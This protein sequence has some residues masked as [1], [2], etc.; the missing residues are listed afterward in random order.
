MA[1][2]SLDGRPVPPELP[3]AQLTA[4][5]HRGEWE[6]RLW[7]AP[8]VALGHV[9]LPRT[10]EAEREFL[11]MSDGTGRYWLTWDGRLDN[12][13]EL[14]PKLGYDV[15]ER[16]EK[17]DA[18]YVLDSF[19]K[20]GDDCVHHL[21]GDWAVV[22]WDNEARRLFCAKDPLGWRQLYYA[23][24]EGLLAVGSE[25]Q[26]FFADGWLP[27]VPNEEYVLRFLADAV[28]ET[29]ETCHVGVMDLDGGLSMTVSDRSFCRTRFWD[30]P[31]GQRLRYR[32]PEQYVEEFKHLFEK[33]VASRL[34]SNRP[35]GILLS[36]GLD[37]SYV[38]AVAADQAVRPLAL[39]GYA[40]GTALMDERKYARIVVE[41]LKLTS[42]EI[43][44]S[45]CWAMSSSW[46]PD[47]AFDDINHAP[48]F[49]SH[50]K[51]ARIAR[52]NGVGVLLGGDGADDWMSGWGWTG[53]AILAGRWRTAWRLSHA[54]RSRRPARWFVKCLYGDL[55]PH[56]GKRFVEACR[57]RPL[58]SFPAFVVTSSDWQLIPQF[59][60][61]KCWP[62]SQLIAALTTHHRQVVRRSVAWRERH[63]MTPN[64]VEHRA[65][66]QDLRVINLMASTPEWVKRFQGSRKDILRAAELDRLPA[67]IPERMDNGV[68][69]ELLESGV[70]DREARRVE[71]AI[72]TIASLPGV[73]ADRLRAEAELWLAHAHPWGLPVLRAISAGAWLSN[74]G[75]PR[76]ASVD[77]LK[78]NLQVKE[79]MA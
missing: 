63:A 58:R 75:V 12:R 22:I 41:H 48:Q 7:E 5:A 71:A 15:N 10:P 42:V 79:V 56:W 17:T 76:S 49:A 23:E 66:F 9:N 69:N 20:W 43:D 68:F 40:E 78:Q 3:R 54:R 26:Q 44:I 19:I 16:A 70:R 33:A 60:D 53:S 77:R 67:V 2:V 34:R 13:D 35:I 46:I 50:M 4:I 29:G 64:G 62:H 39:T 61:A 28:Q 52:D 24:H 8:G 27:K 73:E 1:I 38:A 18:E 32:Q 72:D 21:L 45:D 59:G 6:P 47:C 25:P 65:P 37:S 55:T 30:R 11:P 31:R 36:G 14:G 57:R 51:L 74:L